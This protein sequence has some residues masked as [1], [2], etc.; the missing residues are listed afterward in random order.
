MTMDTKDNPG[1]VTAIEKQAIKLR[2]VL[3]FSDSQSEEERLVRAHLSELLSTLTRDIEIGGDVVSGGRGDF[4]GGN[5][6]P[7]CGSNFID[8]SDIEGDKVC[9][10]CGLTEYGSISYDRFLELHVLR[11]ALRNRPNRGYSPPRDTDILSARAIRELFA[12]YR[13]VAKSP[14]VTTGVKLNA[15]TQENG[16]GSRRK[17]TKRGE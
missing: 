6:C 5:V 14:G 17:Y 11:W 15:R 9:L 1:D 3:E 7:R 10:C 2:W 4:G 8:H 13:V 16:R 12:E